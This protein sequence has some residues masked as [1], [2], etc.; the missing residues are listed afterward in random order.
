MSGL[1]LDMVTT[2]NFNVHLSKPVHTKHALEVMC[3][4]KAFTQSRSHGEAQGG[5]VQAHVVAG[6]TPLPVCHRYMARKVVL[7]QPGVLGCVAARLLM[8]F[9]QGVSDTGAERMTAA[10]YEA[11][12]SYKKLPQ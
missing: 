5:A 6:A 10:Q 4:V 2:E 7:E 9:V 11:Q 12:R 1:E 3:W 8:R